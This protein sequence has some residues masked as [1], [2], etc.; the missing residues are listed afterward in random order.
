VQGDVTALHQERAPSRGAALPRVARERHGDVRARA[1][2][3]K[4]ATSDKA[5]P[6]RSDP[7]GSGERKW[8]NPARGLPPRPCF[9]CCRSCR[10]RA[11]RDV[12]GPTCARGS[13]G[14]N[15]RRGFWPASKA[16]RWR[17]S[18]RPGTSSCAM[19]APSVKP[20]A[21]RRGRRGARRPVG[22]SMRAACRTRGLAR[23]PG[24]RPS[25][26]D[27]CR[28]VV[29]VAHAACPRGQARVTR[30]RAARADTHGSR[31]SGPHRG[32]S[33]VSC[34]FTP[35][36][37]RGVLRGPLP[38]RARRGVTAPC[39]STGSGRR[40]YRRPPDAPSP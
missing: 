31:L 11:G 25:G 29:P 21:R 28:A 23:E 1:R 5:L 22:V 17:A 19:A 16:P 33:A 37:E 8:R 26:R 15:S 18:F 39:G 6:Y 14:S 10:P 9:R 12:H 32:Q 30:R 13:A 4:R 3:P 36:L 40:S 24:R 7:L 27:A 2:G 35:Y 20:G 38:A 34:L